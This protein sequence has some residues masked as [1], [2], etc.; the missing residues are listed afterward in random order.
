MVD[1]DGIAE[2]MGV[3]VIDE[4]TLRSDVN[5]MYVDA[6]RVI[7]VQPNLD[8]W[9]RRSCLAHELAHAF[10]RDEVSEP[11]IERRADQWAAQLL[12][13]PAEYKA[14]ELLVGPSVGALAWELEVTPQ[15]IETW[16]ECY[17]AHV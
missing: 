13:S 1:I 10:F 14:A 4:P 9:N 6:E 7:L 11:R 8:P 5:A 12:I 16:R 3:T 15:V 2:A 17:Q